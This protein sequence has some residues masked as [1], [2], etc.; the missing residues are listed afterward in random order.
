MV[1]ERER[2]HGE[3]RFQLLQQSAFSFRLLK[4]QGVLREI[5]RNLKNIGLGELLACNT[6]YGVPIVSPSLLAV[7][8]DRDVDRC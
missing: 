8:T 3:G 4:P 6:I 7:V 2:H 5:F 1:C